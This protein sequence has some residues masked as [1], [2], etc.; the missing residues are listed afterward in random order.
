M[1]G[2]MRTGCDFKNIYFAS[3]TDSKYLGASNKNNRALECRFS[4]Y[5]YVRIYCDGFTQSII[6]QWLDKLAPNM[7]Q[8]PNKQVF[9]MLSAP[10]NSRG[11][12]VCAVGAASI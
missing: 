4:V 3:L 1:V 12:A 2:N 7:C 9:S 10:R 8:K 5:R 11:C 6:K